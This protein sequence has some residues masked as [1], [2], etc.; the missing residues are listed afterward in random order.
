MISPIVDARRTRTLNTCS[1]QLA[2]LVVYVMASD[3]PKEDRDAFLEELI[4]RRELSNNY[5][6]YTREYTTVKAA[7]VWAQKLLPNMH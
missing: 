1:V 2:G 4:V 7:H 5:C 3:A 6:F